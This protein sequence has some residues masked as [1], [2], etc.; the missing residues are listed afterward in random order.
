MIEQEIIFMSGE[1]IM[2]GTLALPDSEGLFAGVL[3][4]PGSGQVDR[5][6]NHWKLRSKA[7]YQIASY[8]ADH[9]IASLRYDKRGI[10]A[11]D[12]NYWETGFYDN[13]SDASL[14][15]G[16]LKAHKMIE[17]EK[18]FLLGHSEGALI[19]TRLAADGTNVAGVIL[20]AGSAQR[21]ED[22]WKWQAQYVAEDEIRLNK[23]LMKLTH[24]NVQ[25]A[26]QKQLDNIKRSSKDWFR[27]HLIAKMNAKWMREFLAYNPAEDLPKIRVPV[28]AMTGSKD[29]QVNPEDLKLMAELVKTD[30]EYHELPDV[31]HIL[32]VDEGKPTLSTYTKQ[33]R[34]PIDSRILHIILEWLRK[35]I[36]AQR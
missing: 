15:L 28:L 30:F 14:A 2:A 18:V 36:D 25:K 16:Y 1:L 34:K 17:P 10:G 24:Y 32:R 19:S 6:E 22:V 23:W 11:S 9:G 8:L 4:V 29:I 27:V 33:A 31:T 21:G 26:Q 12:G 20:L 3:L 7:S 13:V 35:Q 5:N